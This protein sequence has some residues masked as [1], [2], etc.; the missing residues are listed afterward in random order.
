VQKLTA[1]TVC[2]GLALMWNVGHAYAEFCIDIDHLNRF[3]LQI[4]AETTTSR[5]SV[6]SLVGLRESVHLSPVTGTLFVEPETVPTQA[7]VTLANV[8]NNDV[9][10]TYTMHLGAVG[11]PLGT[12]FTGLYSVW[13]PSSPVPVGNGAASLVDC[14]TG[15]LTHF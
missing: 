14:Q 13:Q 9:I 8:G 3:Y 11:D 12:A 5:G 10:L 7:R 4:T 2:V 1:V 15:A 6:L